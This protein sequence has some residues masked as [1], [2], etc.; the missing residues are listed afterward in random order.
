M[1][2]N[3]SFRLATPNDAHSMLAIYAPSIERSSVSF[4]VDLP[5]LEEFKKRVTDLTSKTPWLVC[6]V[7]N[8]VV[9]YAYASEHR[10]RKA[11]QWTVEVSVYI[12]ATYQ[13]QGIGKR[14]YQELFPILCKQGYFTALAGITLPNESSIKLHESLGF[15]KI[16]VYENVGFKFGK[17]HDVGWW[18]LALRPYSASPEELIPFSKL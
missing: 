8:V 16:A 5:S 2:K 9:G 6:E 17:W 10:A 15:K 14:L 1:Q 18:Q 13:G 12:A 7:D 4:E 11:Y 3:Y